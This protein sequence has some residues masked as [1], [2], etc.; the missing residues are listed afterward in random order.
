MEQFKIRIKQEYVKLLDLL[1]RVFAA[2]NYLSLGDAEENERVLITRGLTDKFKNH[3]VTLLYLSRGTS[4]DFPSFKF[5]LVDIASID[6][7]TRASLEAFLVF[8]YVFYAPATKEE[9]DYRYWAYKAAGIAERQNFPPSSVELKQKL[10]VEKEELD[11]LY[12]QLKSN[13]VFQNLTDN[14]K[15]Q[16]LRGRWKL[17]SWRAIAIDAGVSEMIASRM[18][19]F[20]AGYAH[21]SMLSVVQMVEAHRDRREEVHVNSA[22]VI[23]NLMIANMVREYCGLFSK[24]QEVLR[25]DHEGSYIVDW[26]IQVDRYL[27]EFTKIGQDND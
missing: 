18:Y 19:S 5:S 14:Q 8:H 25:K 27:N 26:W 11:K 24:A 15:K 6:V 4:L 9:K 1:A 2:D 16:V 3:A 22:M 23:M 13:S 12:Q 20:L 10:V 21:S 7:L 17:P